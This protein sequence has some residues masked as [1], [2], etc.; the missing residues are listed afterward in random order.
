MHTEAQQTVH[1]RLGIVLGRIGVAALVVLVLFGLYALFFL[2]EGGW[3]L[4][5]VSALGGLVL[6]FAGRVLR[7]ILSG[8]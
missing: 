2:G 5:L 1:G 6:F 4:G 3:A 8:D 7:Y